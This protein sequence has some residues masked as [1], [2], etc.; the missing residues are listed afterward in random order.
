MTIPYEPLAGETYNGWHI[1]YS[2]LRSTHARWRAEREDGARLYA[3]SATS[4][5]TKMILYDNEE[6]GL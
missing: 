3:G 2:E 6:A 4:L 1:A 5:G